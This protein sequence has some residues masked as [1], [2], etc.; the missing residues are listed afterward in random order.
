MAATVVPPHSFPGLDSF[1][2]RSIRRSRPAYPAWPVGTR[3]VAVLPS[4]S[5]RPGAGVRPT[6]A[7]YHRRRVVA[8]VLLVAVS[9]IVL[10]GISTVGA[11]VLG[12]TATAAPVVAS[13]P[14]ASTAGPARIH[15]VQPGDTLWTIARS[16]QPEGDVR[17]LVDQLAE[18]HGGAGLRVGERLDLYALGQ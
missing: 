16:M 4:V 15:V 6:A 17:P 10:L 2:P 1:R 13:A 7:V 5:N 9:A 8:L 18:R 12:A 14:G 11:R 3:P